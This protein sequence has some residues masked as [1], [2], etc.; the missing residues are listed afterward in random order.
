MSPTTSVGVMGWKGQPITPTNI[1]RTPRPIQGLSRHKR[2][3]L[4]RIYSTIPLTVKG[5]AEVW[6]DKP[7]ESKLSACP[8]MVEV[9]ICQTKRCNKDCKSP[10]H[11]HCEVLKY[12]HHN[13]VQVKGVIAYDEISYA[14]V[15]KSRVRIKKRIKYYEKIKNNRCRRSW[16][17]DGKEQ[18]CRK[19]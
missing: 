15:Y 6:K 11:C 1:L 5:L 19:N 2:G 16:I 14:F 17:L 12:K 4:V 7:A 8:A 18:N 9:Q 3:Q 13:R 10:A